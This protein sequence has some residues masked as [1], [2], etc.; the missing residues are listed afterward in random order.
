M[1]LEPFIEKNITLMATYFAELSN[2]L[3]FNELFTRLFKIILKFS[4]N[5][6]LKYFSLIFNSTFKIFQANPKQNSF[7]LSVFSFTL[8]ILD[9]EPSLGPWLKDNYSEFNRFLLN[10]MI[11]YKDPDLIKHFTSLQA[12][13]VLYDELVF[14]CS[15][16]YEE[17][18]KLLLESL[19]TINE[20]AMTKEILL[21]FNTFVGVPKGVNHPKT[22]QFLAE[23][24]RVLVFLLPEINR[25]FLNF[26][27]QILQAVIKSY[28]SNNNE[29][30]VFI[31]GLLN[32]ARFNECSEKQKVNKFLKYL[33]S[34]L[35]YRKFLCN[36]FSIS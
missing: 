20:Y 4:Q 3:E 36:V 5:I 1:V 7:V 35:I 30:Y 17:I 22:L 21:F 26:E 29:L 16:E 24:I 18:M 33:R 11:Q 14:L 6:T 31:R 23:M 27:I 19:L 10:N 8:G 13:I 28:G 15:N 9:T 25:N 32:D 34:I 12:R 2:I